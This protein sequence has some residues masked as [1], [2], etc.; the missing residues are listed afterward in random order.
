MTATFYLFNNDTV[1]VIEEGLEHSTLILI[2][3]YVIVK[4]ISFFYS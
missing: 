2:S 3:N 1:K 4:F